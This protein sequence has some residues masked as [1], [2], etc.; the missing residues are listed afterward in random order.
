[1]SDDLEVVYISASAAKQKP[2]PSLSSVSKQEPDPWLSSLPEKEPAPSSNC[3]SKQ[4]PEPSHNCVDK[5]EPE[6]SKCPEGRRDWFYTLF[7]PCF[8]KKYTDIYDGKYYHKVLWF[9]YTCDGKKCAGLCAP[10]GE[11]YPPEAEVFKPDCL[12]F[13]ALTLRFIRIHICCDDNDDD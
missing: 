8:A 4:E 9:K 2:G 11:Y 5:Q 12:F 13:C 1:M 6:Y 3:V 7:G 10:P